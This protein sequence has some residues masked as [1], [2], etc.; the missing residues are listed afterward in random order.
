M[1]DKEKDIGALW[2]KHGNAGPYF[3]GSIEID[4]KKIRIIA[5]KNG[6]KK[7]DAQ[8]DWRIYPQR[9]QGAPRSE[10][11]GLAPGYMKP[12]NTPPVDDVPT[13]NYPTEDI[14]PND[15]PF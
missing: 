5:F 2:E 6:Y 3:T 12:E 10:S 4:G 9:E 8:P 14:D 15:I 7:T 1:A 11:S 13:I